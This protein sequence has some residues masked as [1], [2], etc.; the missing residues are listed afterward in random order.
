MLKRKLIFFLVTLPGVI[1][2]SLPTLS[3]AA[4]DG[5][6]FLK[7]GEGVKALGM[8]GAFVAI[9]DD[10]SAP[11]WNPAGIARAKEKRISEVS[12]LRERIGNV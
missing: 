1:L 7:I 4:D 5:A 9:A 11:L 3:I 12:R 8:G 6:A 10:G 2:I